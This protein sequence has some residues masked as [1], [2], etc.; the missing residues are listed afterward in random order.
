MGEDVE[1]DNEKDFSIAERQILA[2]GRILTALWDTCSSHCLVSSAF[3]AELVNGGARFARDVNMPM[4]QGKIWTGTIKSRVFCDISIA[5]KG[6]VKD[7]PNTCLYVWD[8]GRP[9]ALSKSFLTK[10]GICDMEEAKGDYEL[11]KEHGLRNESQATKISAT[12]SSH[13]LTQAHLEADNAERVSIGGAQ[14][15][16]G[17][18]GEIATSAAKGIREKDVGHTTHSVR[19]AWTKEKAEALRDSL[20]EQMRTPYPALA[21]ALEQVAD[22][23]PAAFGEDI[24]EPSLLKKF[25][26]KLKN[27]ASY[28]CMVPRRLSE[29]MLVEVQKQIAALLAQGVIRKSSSPFAFPIVLARRPGSDKI[30]VCCDFR[31]LNEMTEPYP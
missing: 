15:H 3:A 13:D 17:W 23:F 25:K 2:G 7:F 12:F 1:E 21:Q 27:G 26:V 31:L 18:Q 8:T 5:H 30:R 20:R 24:S 4:K 29:P 10:A 28:V 14:A 22:E 19:D 16:A 11:L 6:K 9:L